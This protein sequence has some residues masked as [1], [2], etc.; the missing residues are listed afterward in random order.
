VKSLTHCRRFGWTGLGIVIFTLLTIAVGTPSF[1]LEPDQ[2]LLITNKNVPDSQKLAD[3]Y[4]D[5]RHI[6]AD[7]IVSLDLPD[8]A[9]MPFAT[10]ETNVVPPVREFL[11]EHHLQNRITCLLT[12]YGVPFRIGAKSNTVAER[13]ELFDLQQR[14]SALA[15][16]CQKAVEELEQQAEKLDPSFK[17]AIDFSLQGLDLRMHAAISA[18][19]PKINAIADPEQR[20]QAIGFVAK[21]MEPLGGPTEAD[22][23]THS[24]DEIHAHT[25]QILSQIHELQNRR[26]DPAA[27]AQIRE[28]AASNLGKLG[29]AEA[30]AQQA[31]YFQTEHTESATD[32][33]L[34]LLWW[35]AYPRANSLANS[36]NWRMRSA[37]GQAPALMVMRLDGPNPDIVEKMIRTSVEVE[38]TGLRGVVALDA[39]GLQPLDD[40]GNPNPLGAYDERIRELAMY[41]HAKTNLSVKLDDN[42][43]VFAP[44]SVKDV[45]IY[46]G[47]YSLNHYVPGCDFNPGA[48][49]FHIASYEMVWLHG[50]QSGWVHGLLSDGVVGTLGPVAEPYL[51]AFPDPLEFYPLLMTGKL[52]LAEVYWKTTPTVSWMMSCIGDP[53]YT[54]YRTNPPLKVEDLPRGLSMAVVGQVPRPAPL[55]GPAEQ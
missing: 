29:T 9:E 22:M 15:A 14:Q 54:P 33:E 17:P 5:L 26:F 20:A 11:V 42:D 16:D 27:R 1:A 6:P 36:L 41:L 39:R 30:I 55:P 53:L 8:D 21:M 48:V 4:A 49:G 50:A 44:H 47:W 13:K 25:A 37:S 46:C 45:A 19:N 10:Y 31:V 23:A 52:S 40:K 28:L 43:A 24:I 34:S 12:F 32:S 35:T 18:I 51:S 3:L 38:K 7:R 2:I